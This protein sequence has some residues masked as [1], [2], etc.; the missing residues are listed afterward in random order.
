[1][2]E[3]SPGLLFEASNVY[4]VDGTNQHLLLVEAYGSRHFR[5]WTAESLDGPWT[6]LADTQQSPFAR[7]A[8]VTFD[9]S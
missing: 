1:M 4:E 3:P 7:A 6:P 9:G 5:S 2:S 8:S